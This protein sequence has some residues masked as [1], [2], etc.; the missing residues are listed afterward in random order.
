VLFSSFFTNAAGPLDSLRTYQPWLT[1][2]AGETPHVHPWS[3]YL[4][5]LLFFHISKG[6]VW[7]E[8]VIAV[9]A[10][11]GAAAGFTRN[12][13]AGADPG[14]IRF[15]AFYTLLLT[16]IYAIIPY[17]TPWC[18]ANFWHPAILLAGV[19]AAFLL[20]I[21]RKTGLRLALTLLIG[22]GAIH[23][24]WQARQ[25]DGQYA[26]DAGNPYAYVQTLPNI[27]EL[28]E[29]VEALAE[30]HP[31][32]H[33]MLIKVMAPENEYWPLPWYLRRFNHVFAGGK[34][35]ADPFAPVMIVSAQFD[36]KLDEQ[37]THLMAGYFELRPREFF[38]LY[39]EVGL[40][41]DYLGKKETN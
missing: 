3:F 15:L 6:P 1:R 14:F 11:A 40:W 16:G 33:Q 9:L 38:E 34:L 17:K 8:I 21:I 31:H 26:S 25:Q 19:G 39:V 7:S 23:L 20:G 30:V 18:L 41:R 22:A 36:A 28:V 5:R 35:P 10:V 12:R 24:A 37:K 32:H 27:L 13:Q 29:K 4:H 2:A